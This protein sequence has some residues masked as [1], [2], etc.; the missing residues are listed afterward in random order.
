MPSSN[1]EYVSCKVIPNEGVEESII[2]ISIPIGLTSIIPY[3]KE[4]E[5]RRVMLKALKAD[6][7]V[8]K[9]IEL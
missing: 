7:R 8:K 9:L 2:K 1:Y 5:V 3:N 4:V 6:Y